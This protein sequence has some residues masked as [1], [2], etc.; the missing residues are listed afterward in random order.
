[1]KTF[2]DYAEYWHISDAD[3]SYDFA[4]YL[5]A[6]RKAGS[7]ENSVLALLIMWTTLSELTKKLSHL[8]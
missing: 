5:E 1:M 4:E 6:T 2:S 7:T 8:P 3:R